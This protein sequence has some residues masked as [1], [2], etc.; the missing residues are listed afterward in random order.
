MNWIIFAIASAVFVAITTVIEKKTLIKQHAAKFSTT[1][2]LFNVLISLIYIPFVDFGISW[3]AI[4]FIFV[5]SIFGSVAFLFLAKGI[6]HT[7]VSISSPLLNFGPAVTALLAFILLGEIITG[8]QI[9]GIGVLIVGTYVLEVDHHP[10]HL[11]EPF[12]KMLKSKYIMFIFFAILLYG[13]SGIMDKYILT[14][15]KLN[16]YTFLF[17]V[18]I[19]V[20]IIFLLIMSVYYGGIKEIASGLKSLWKYVGLIA[21]LVTLARLSYLQAVSLTF[22]SLVV[23]IKRLST[24]LVTIFGGTFFHEKGLPLKI[25]GCIIMLIG[26]FFLVFP[27]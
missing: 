22:V 3:Q 19:F 25:I 18:H 23:P 12:K 11:L 26:V 17:F 21:I 8:W 16:I 15:F 9:L 6:R 5:A 27:F 2:A 14:E 20:A 13:L 7:E 10:R 24:L 1:L 4:F